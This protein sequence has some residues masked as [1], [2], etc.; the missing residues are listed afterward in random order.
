M[1]NNSEQ[2]QASVDLWLDLRS[3]VENLLQFGEPAKHLEILEFIYEAYIASDWANDP[4]ERRNAQ[5]EYGIYRDLLRTLQRH[6]T[7]LHTLPQI[8]C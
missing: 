3:Q 6:A 2:K 5:V 1:R 8:P 4:Q 7:T